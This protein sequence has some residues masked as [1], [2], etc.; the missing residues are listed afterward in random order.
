V[1]SLALG[2]FAVSKL[3]FPERGLDKSD[4]TLQVCHELIVF[5]LSNVILTDKAD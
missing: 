5:F 4:S 3:E 2:N 1:A